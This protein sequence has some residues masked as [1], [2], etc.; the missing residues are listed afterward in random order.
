MHSPARAFRARSTRAGWEGLEPGEGDVLDIAEYDLCIDRRAQLAAI[1]RV[2]PPTHTAFF[3]R[4][5]VADE[6]WERRTLGVREPIRHW[7]R[8]AGPAQWWQRR[9]P[10]FLPNSFTINLSGRSPGIW[11]ELV[12]RG[13]PED[14]N[15]N[16]SLD[17]WKL[18]F[19]MGRSVAREQQLPV[20]M[21]QILATAR[22]EKDAGAV[23]ERLLIWAGGSRYSVPTV[24]D[25]LAAYASA[26][27]LVATVEPRAATLSR[28]AKPT[29]RRRGKADDAAPWREQRD[30]HAIARTADLHVL[31]RLASG[32]AGTAWEGEPRGALSLACLLAEECEVGT[33]LR[34]AAE[35][36]MSVLFGLGTDALDL[37]LDARVGARITW[38]GFGFCSGE[39]ELWQAGAS[40]VDAE[41]A[42]WELAVRWAEAGPDAPPLNQYDMD[43]LLGR[44][45]Y[46]ESISQAVAPTHEPFRDRLADL[47]ARYWRVSSPAPESTTT[48]ASIQPAAWWWHRV[49]D[50]VPADGERDRWILW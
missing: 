13:I 30:A 47:D 40:Y 39:I 24:D 14:P 7:R 20:P 42:A 1:E 22:R 28:L 11:A 31:E 3:E 34:A 43:G 29:G 44:R 4:L 41:F 12:E 10:R 33:A 21:S 46:L 26:R 17:A 15:H 8:S 2:L 36:P 16:P 6:R 23:R 49:P 35:D 25:V 19:G 37:L 38:P 45:D 9:V 5:T 32:E 48:P 50:V 27:E 18:R